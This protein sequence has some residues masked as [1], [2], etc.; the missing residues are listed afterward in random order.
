MPLFTDKTLDTVGNVKL[1]SS[2]HD[3]GSFNTLL[4]LMDNSNVVYTPSASK[5][6]SVVGAVDFFIRTYAGN[7][8]VRNDKDEFIFSNELSE[9]PEGMTLNDYVLLCARE[10]VYNTY[11]E[12]REKALLSPE[13]ALSTFP[14]PF[15]IYYDRLRDV[16]VALIQICANSLELEG[17]LAKGLRYTDASEDF[18]KYLEDR[19]KDVKFKYT[20]K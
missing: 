8:I 6:E 9:I 16:N 5:C 15:G 17:R 20:L 12:N 11:S 10:V 19:V 18:I 14:I 3:N 2:V 4:M 7:N 1:T 13:I